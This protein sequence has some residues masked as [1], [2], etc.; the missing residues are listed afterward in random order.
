MAAVNDPRPETRGLVGEGEKDAEQQGPEPDGGGPGTVV[1][2]GAGPAGLTAAYELAKRGA[3]CTVLEMDTVVGGLARTV[4]RE[5]WRFDIGGHRFFT[6][7]PEVEAVWREIL[8]P[9]DFLLRRRLSRIYYEGTYYDYPIRLGNA[10]RGLG[11]V[12][13]ARCAMSFLFVRVHPPKDLDTF[14]GWTARAFGWRL[15]R[16]FFKTYTEKIWGMPAS[17]IKADWAAQ[18]IKSLTLGKAIRNALAPNKRE[19]RVTSLIDEFHYP[20]LGPGMM[21]ERAR[22]LVEAQGSKVLFGT[23]LERIRRSDGRALQAVTR[24]VLSPERSGAAA[25]EVGDVTTWPFDHLVSSMPLSDLVQAMDPPPP[26]HVLESARA[27]RYRD[28][29]T[30]ALVLPAERGFPDNWIYVHSDKV[31]VGRVQNFGSWSRDLVKQGRTCLG[32]EYFVFEGDELWS[33][34]DD[35]LVAL[36]KKELETLGLVRPGDV[37]RGYV[38][39]VEKAYPVYDDG[40]GEKLQAIRDWLKAEVPNVHPVGRNG[41]HR[42]NNQDHS[43]LTAMLTVEGLYGRPFNT[44]DVN[45]EADYHEQQV[46]NQPNASARGTQGTGRS[47]PTPVRT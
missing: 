13:S 29:L 39:R 32:L 35:D 37:E 11:L 40:Y 14:E 7:V 25:G 10:L 26:E 23:R 17:A 8:G 9:E 38:V 5:G 6:K 45:V 44:W 22:E 30:V 27:L 16:K 31:R 47:H 28:F 20:R 46:G 2:V 3:T 4:E 36:G 19:T 41:M 42:Y 24:S 1:V 34:A 21:W 18:R 15:Y 43:M 12:E 33:T